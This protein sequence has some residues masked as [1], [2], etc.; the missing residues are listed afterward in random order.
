MQVKIGIRFHRADTTYFETNRLYA[1]AK[2]IICKG[3]HQ[4]CE[5]KNTCKTFN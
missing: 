4:D 1:Y 5:N 3:T 2:Q